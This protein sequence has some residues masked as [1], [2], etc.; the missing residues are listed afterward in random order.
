MHEEGKKN[1]LFANFLKQGNVLPAITCPRL[2]NKNISRCLSLRADYE[3][4]FSVNLPPSNIMRYYK[5]SQMS[6]D[7]LYVS[8]KIN[9][10]ICA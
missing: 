10:G 4:W 6:V 5:V 2:R 9:N 1:F 8:G 7:Q 3:L